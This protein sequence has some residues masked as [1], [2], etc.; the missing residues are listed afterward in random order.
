M[1]IWTSVVLALVVLGGCSDLGPG[2]ESGWNWYDLPYGRIALPPELMQVGSIAALPVNPE[3]AGVVNGVRLRVQFCIYDSPGK[4]GYMEYEGKTGYLYGRKVVM[5][6]SFG[7]FH[8]YDSHFS[9]MLGMKAYFRPVGNPLE[10]VVDL[11][12]P[13]AEEIAQAILLTM[14]P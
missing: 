8:G 14:H 9:T 5:F 7:S 2:G 3:Y 11:E 13:G 4:W 12:S 1:R 6:K 10:V